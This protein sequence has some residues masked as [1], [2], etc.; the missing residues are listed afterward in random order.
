MPS[1]IRPRGVECRF[2]TFGRLPATVGML[3][4]IL[5]AWLSALA[6]A[7]VFRSGVDVV[8]LGVTVADRRGQLVSDLTADNF[9]I[10]EDGQLQ[11]LRFFASASGPAPELH[12]GLLLDVS[13]SM[14]DEIAFTRTA[15]IKVLNTLTEAVDIT[16]VDFDTEVRVA[17]YGQREFPRLVERIRSQKPRGQTALFDAIGVYLDGAAQQE[18]RKVMLLYTDGGDTRSAMRLSEL[19]DLI[20][21]SDVTI[22]CIGALE[23]G[24]VALRN[25]QQQLLR[26]LAEMT[27]GQVFFSRSV[28]ELD[29]LY[30]QMASEI[31]AQYLLGYASTNPR[32]D[33]A[34][35]TL[36]IR[37]KHPEERGWKVRTRQG[38]FA[39]LRK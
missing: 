23:A 34:W 17:R 31:R 9:E 8:N 22:Y 36:E 4:A 30:K 24:T 25:E 5:G 10:R 27:G 3:I 12:L 11:T 6:Q 15:S 35:R 26:R 21:A 16:L 28:K 18:G 33:G 20:R 32:T 19:L 29:A 2:V 1:E 38:Y 14:Q 37:V 7:P 13:E 39:P